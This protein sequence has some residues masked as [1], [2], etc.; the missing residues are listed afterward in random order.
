[1]SRIVL[2]SLLLQTPLT[3]LL[4]VTGVTECAEIV[5]CR[6]LSACGQIVR[7]VVKGVQDQLENALLALGV[8]EKQLL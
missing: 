6:E 4:Y 2:S 5:G 7:H 3:C 1:M 8:L